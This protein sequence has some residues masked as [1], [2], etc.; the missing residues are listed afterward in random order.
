MLVNQSTTLAFVWNKS[1]DALSY[2]LQVAS[3]SNFSAI[4]FSQGFISD[5]SQTVN[6]LIAST[7]Y[8]WRV[9]ASY[10]TG[11]ISS[12][13]WHFATQAQNVVPQAPTLFL[14]LMALLA[15]STTRSFPGILPTDLNRSRSRFQPPYF[16]SL[17][18]TT[19]QLQHR[20]SNSQSFSVCPLL[21]PRR[22]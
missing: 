7:M 4:L 16:S 11:C 22:P 9:F 17:L 12:P 20:A 1:S 21:L 14:P 8:Y 3:D 19:A 10:S 18:Q 15:S 13:V 6:A 2:T 5:T